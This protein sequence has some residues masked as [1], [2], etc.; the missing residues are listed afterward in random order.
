MTQPGAKGSRGTVIRLMYRTGLFMIRRKSSTLSS[1]SAYFTK[2]Y[3]GARQILLDVNYRSKKDIV[4]VAGKLL[5]P[6]FSI[7]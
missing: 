3:P 4:D 7:T 6:I 1:L 2:D 5:S